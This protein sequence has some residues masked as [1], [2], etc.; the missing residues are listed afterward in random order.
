MNND[1]KV[2][3]EINASLQK[4][5]KRLDGLEENTEYSNRRLSNLIDKQ[6]SL[7][8]R[9]NYHE[10]VLRDRREVSE[11][12]FG[13]SQKSNQ[14]SIDSLKTSPGHAIL[15]DDESYINKHPSYL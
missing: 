10:D 6:R 1:Q 11:R 5:A 2:L 9:L 7:E 3:D 13:L 12:V 14:K 8:T 4:I 15:E